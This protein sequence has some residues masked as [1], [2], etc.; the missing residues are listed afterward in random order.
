MTLRRVDWRFALPNPLERV[1]VIG[2]PAVWSECLADAG[3]RLVESEPDLVVASAA[4]TRAVVR[5]K[6]PSA[7]TEGWGAVRRLRHAFP[8]VSRLL[9][10]PNVDAPEFLLP[11]D[12]A[13]G[14]L[15]AIENLLDPGNVRW[16]RARNWFVQGVIARHSLPD[17]VPVVTFARH[18][19]S[20]PFMIAASEAFGVPGDCHWFLSLGRGDALTRAV[21]HLVPPEATDPSWVIKFARV[22]GYREPFE[23]DERGLKLAGKI[24]GAVPAPSLVGRFEAHGLHA[25]IETAA[26]GQSLTRFLKRRGAREAKL[27]V[28][29]TIAAWIVG[30]GRETAKPVDALGGER[31]R[32]EQSVIPQW[33]A[34]VQPLDLGSIF[35]AIRGVLQHNDLGCWN[36]VVDGTTFT[37]LDWESAR[38]VGLPLWDLLYFLVDALTHLDGAWR[39]ED[40]DRYTRRLFRGEEAS[41]EVLF[42]WVATA[43][44]AANVPFEHVGAIT[45]LC[46]LHHGLSFEARSTRAA[47]LARDLPTPPASARG[48]AEVWVSDPDLCPAWDAWRSRVGTD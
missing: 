10:I 44:R 38:E 1:Q 25:S 2:D 5:C 23:R 19:P 17:V 22:P 26:V 32:L 11:L 20:P 47:E 29:E 18:D 3:A 41:S 45:T 9:P 8:V 14:S 4:L 31:L 16:K 21:F 34:V 43:A 36:I 12:E 40:R 15:Y 6:P 46:W 27:A 33:S 28:V 48:I 24:G 30:L 35:S 42:T 39:P 13:A 7:L 37:A